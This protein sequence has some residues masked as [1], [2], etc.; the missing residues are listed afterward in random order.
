MIVREISCQSTQELFTSTTE[1]LDNNYI[2][3]ELRTFRTLYSSLL[4]IMHRD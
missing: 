2:N 4:N 1:G 3:S